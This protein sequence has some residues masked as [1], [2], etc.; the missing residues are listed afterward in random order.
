MNLVGEG[1]IVTGVLEDVF[2]VIQLENL[3]PD[4]FHWAGWDLGVSGDT[5]TS[6]AGETPRQHLQNPPGSNKI[7]VVTKVGLLSTQTQTFRMHVSDLAVADTPTDT[8]AFRDRRRQLTTLPV[9]RIFSESSA[10]ALPAAEVG[11]MTLTANEQFWLEVPDGIVVLNPGSQLIFRG[12]LVNST[13]QS[14]FF[15]RERVEEPS[16]A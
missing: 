15:W 12:L 3:E 2:P 4:G 11:F 1:S 10:A 13:L 6:L 5:L 16:E 9:V 8:P 14:I 7:A